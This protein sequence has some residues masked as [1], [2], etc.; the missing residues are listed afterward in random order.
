MLL[1]G[2]GQHQVR[3]ARIVCQLAGSIAEMTPGSFQSVEGFK[4]NENAIAKPAG[5]LARLMGSIEAAQ[6]RGVVNQEK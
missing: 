2:I 1:D 5:K 3:R 6:Q 4:R